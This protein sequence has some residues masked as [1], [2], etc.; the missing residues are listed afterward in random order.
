MKIE[1]IVDGEDQRKDGINT[2]K[3]NDSRT[4]TGRRAKLKA[5]LNVKMKST[6][7]QYQST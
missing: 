6:W 5:R 4:I 1:K 2:T 7:Q 3:D